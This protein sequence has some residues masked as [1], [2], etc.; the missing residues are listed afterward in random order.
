MSSAREIPYPNPPLTD[1][2]ITIR[3]LRVDD[4]ASIASWYEDE[5]TRTEWLSRVMETPDEARALIERAESERLVGRLYMAIAAST[6]DLIVGFGRLHCVGDDGLVG[7]LGVILAPWARSMALATPGGAQRPRG[8]L[9]ARAGG[10]VI[11]W[12]FSEL[13]LRRL[14][15]RSH[16]ANRPSIGLLEALGFRR[17]GVLRQYSPTGDDVIFG[18]VPGDLV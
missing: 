2:E 18:L 17:E 15:A 8:S 1:G 14:Q 4:A 13:G 6:N 3:A 12:A 16:P 11:G 9:A 10:M 7:E 5:A